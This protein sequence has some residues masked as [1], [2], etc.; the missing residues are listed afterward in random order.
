MR[1]SIWVGL[2]FL[3]TILVLGGCKKGKD[4]YKDLPKEL[5]ELSRQIDK[6]PKK[7]EL[8]YQRAQYYYARGFIKEG[9]QDAAS[10]VKLDEKNPD[11][12]VLISDLYF[13]KRETDLAEESLLKAIELDPKHNEARLKL[14][15]L[16]Y[17]LGM[18]EECNKTLDET[19]NLQPFNPTAH[20]I[21]AFCLKEQQDTTEMLRI[22]QLVIDQNPNEKKAFLELGYFYQERLDPLAIQYYQNG[23]R[24][25]PKDKELNFNLARLY[26]DLGE[27]DAAIQQY[28]TILTFDP[29]NTNVFNNLGYIYLYYYDQYDEAIAYFTQAIE[30]DPNFINAICNRGVAF[31][32]S[33]QYSN[34]RQDFE[35]CTTLDPNFEPAI[36]GLNRLDKIKK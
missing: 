25:D 5:A 10:A 22:L 26:Q 1:V 34:A 17:H 6:H 13:A 31:E 15:E 11:Y 29:K 12:R 27:L 16:Y 28:N 2:L 9:F 3:A 4:T 24:V 14:A 20:L 18:L 32:L 36:K 23:L 8:Y 30:I 7:S 19:L 35:T 21:R 33:K